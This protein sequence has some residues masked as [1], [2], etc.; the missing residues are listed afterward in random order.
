M[1]S[2]QLKFTGFI[3]FITFALSS[4]KKEGDG[5]GGGAGAASRFEGFETCDIITPPGEVQLSSYYSKYTNCD[6]I[7]VIGNSAVPDE[8]FDVANATIAFMLQGQTAVQNKLIE[9]GEYYILV[10]PGDTPLDVPE[11]ASSG[12]PN[13]GIYWDQTRCAAS[14]AAGLLCF[15]DNNPDFHNNVFVHEFAHMMD[16]SGLRLAESGFESQLD[17]AFN[18]AS[19]AWGNTYAMTNKAEYFAQSILVYFEVGFP[20]GEAGGDGNW[21]DLT[22]RADLQERDPAMYNLLASRFNSSL[23]T[24][25][26]IHGEEFEPWVDPNINC[27]TT[28]TDIDGNT[29]NVV[30]IGNQCWIDKNLTTTRFKDGTTI[31]NITDDT[32]W[33]NASSPAWCNYENSSSNGSTYGKLYNWDAIGNS[34]GICPDGWHVATQEE[35]QNLIAISAAL[36][37]G[38]GGALKSLDFWNQPNEGATNETGFSAIPSG[39]R[40]ADALFEGRLSHTSFWSSTQDGSANAM[41]YGMWENGSFTIEASQDKTRGQACRCVKD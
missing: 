34:S 10:A 26:C 39:V 27:G 29:Y 30:R 36:G 24:P 9:R 7:P 37:S 38:T 32:D 3:L 1:I 28:V 23:N 5:T 14:N 8:A 17:A 21:N 16:I 25:G 35:W 6:G 15:T 19:S 40:R 2:N 31:Q 12:A 33:S 18:T 13:S 11:F 41:S 4:C 20:F 22:T